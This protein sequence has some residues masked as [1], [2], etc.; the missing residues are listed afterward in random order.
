MSKV[1]RV[2]FFGSSEVKAEEKD[3]QDAYQ[4]AKLLA[5]KGF[6]VVNGG[7]PGIMR[8]ASEGAKAAGGKTIGVSFDPTGMTNFEGRDPKNILDEEIEVSSYTGRT[9]KLLELGDAHVFFRGGTGTIS[10]FGMAWALARLYFASRKPL[11]LFGS[12]WHEIMEAFG[13]NMCLRPEELRAYRIV[14]SPE[15]AVEEIIDL[16]GKP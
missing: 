2:T 3:Y 6:I 10:E 5:S 16:I 14:D 12:G 11:I 1:K 13:R 9:A 7:G 8:A 4:V 15:E